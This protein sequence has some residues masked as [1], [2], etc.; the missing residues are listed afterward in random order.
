M[1]TGL[2]ILAAFSL[3]VLNGCASAEP[4]T[5][6][7]QSITATPTPPADGGSFSTLAEL[8]EAYVAAGGD[9]GNLDQANNVKLAAE[10][11]NCN[12]QT[13]ISTY[14]STADVSQVIQNVK[15]LNEEIDFQSDDVWL[16]GQNWI[17]N[18]PDA[19]DMQEKL[20]G[21]LVSFK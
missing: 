8:Q 14:I 21:R 15:A 4:S 9:C 2:L 17:I 16:T 10:S 18:G 6:V 7:V 19:A 11:G 13:V 12:D 3:A 20:G 1:K 5:S